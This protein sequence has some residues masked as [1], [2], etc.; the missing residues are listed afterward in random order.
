MC[1]DFLTPRAVLIAQK[2][3]LS[4]WLEDQQSAEGFVLHPSRR[5]TLFLPFSD[6]VAGW[7]DEGRVVARSELDHRLALCAEGAG[8]V[9]RQGCRVTEGIFDDGLAVGV[10][11]LTRE[12]AELEVRAP[13]V[14]LADGA[15]SRIARQ[16]GLFRENRPYMAV[17]MRAYFEGA[18][19]R[20]P[21]LHFY[22]YDYSL[23][24]YAWIFP[25]G[26]GR[27]NVGI[28]ALSGDTPSL[29]APLKHLLARLL[30]EDGD[31]ADALRGATRVS[32]F[33]AAPLRI[34]MGAGVQAGDGLLLTGDAGGMVNPFSG[35]GIAYALESGQIAARCIAR[36][37][38]ER[39]GSR[40]A[41][42]FY[43]VSVERALLGYFQKAM[44]IVTWAKR[45]HYLQFCTD[46]SR[47]P[48][49]RRCTTRVLTNTRRRAD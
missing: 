16:R 35:E 22:L 31:F 20:E 47:L 2:L 40:R 7:P 46:A 29:G 39:G 48:L 19:L 25:M 13:F 42:E 28:G 9:I 41:E 4:E 37:A 3:G 12:G 14:V 32:P 23:P 34:G 11:A 33:K 5:K 36:A 1:G 18:S 17:A 26:D 49:T 24:A 8:A 15:R 6:G 10:R 44:A 30:S 27:A 38:R 21:R 45:P 43:R